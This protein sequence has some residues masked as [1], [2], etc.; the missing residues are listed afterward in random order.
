LLVSLE[1]FGCDR[2]VIDVR[3]KVFDGELAGAI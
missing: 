3:D 2:D 1:A